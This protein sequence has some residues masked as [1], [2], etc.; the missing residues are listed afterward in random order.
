[1]HCNQC[2]AAVQEGSKFC[3]NCGAKLITLC[4]SCQKENAPDSRFCRHCGTALTGAVPPPKPSP[5]PAPP[6]APAP[7]LAA[8]RRITAV[9]FADIVG[10]TPMSEA[11][12]PEEFREVMNQCFHI[13]TKPI[14]K[15]DGTVDKFI[16]D[17]I[18]ALFGAPHAH[19]NDPER[20][21]RAALEMQQ[22][23][24]RLAETVELPVSEPI[25]LRVGIN[26]GLVITGGV[27]S[28]AKRDYTAMGRVVNVAERMQKLCEPGSVMVSESVHSATR[29]LFDFEDAGKHSVKG[30]AH[31]ISVYRVLSALSRGATTR[32]LQEIGFTTYINRQEELE[33]LK[34]TVEEALQGKATVV[35]IKGPA[36]IGKTRL[37][38]ECQ[39]VMEPAGIRWFWARSLEYQRNVPYA[40]VAELFEQILGLQP[41]VEM[42][43]E[44]HIE[45][46]LGAVPPS[47]E[48]CPMVTGLSF[49][50]R[51]GTQEAAFQGLQGE[52]IQKCIYNAAESLVEG[53]LS[54]S[55][56]AIVIDDLQWC[57]RASLDLFSH[58]LKRFFS[59]RLILCTS[60]RPYSPP[61]WDG[62]NNA[63]KIILGRLSEK[64][65]Q[66]LTY[67]I[68]D[69]ADDY[70]ALSKV[71]E[72][73]LDKCE[74]NA[75]F[76]EE[77]VKLLIDKGILARD[78]SQWKITG[79][80]DDQ[81]LPDSLR[82]MVM[83]RIDRLQAAQKQLLQALSVLGSETS[84]EVLSELTSS[85][86]RDAT[87]NC[88]SQ[89]VDLQILNEE[90]SD[91]GASYSFSRAFFRDAIYD[92]LLK[93]RRRALHSR[94]AEFLESFLGEK[95]RSR[96][97]LLAYHYERAG[98]FERAYYHT[99]EAARQVALIYANS[100]AIDLFERC[101][102][103]LKKWQ[104]EPDAQELLDLM[105]NLA[106]VHYLTGNLS[107][108]ID[109]LEEQI[110]LARRASDDLFVARTHNNIGLLHEHEGNWDTARGH[111]RRAVDIA[112]R[113]SDKPLT[114][115]CLTNLGRL[116]IAVGS[117][118]AARK[119]FDDALRIAESA[120]SDQLHFDS[121]INL[122]LVSLYRCELARADELGRKAKQLA[123]SEQDD[124]NLAWALRV[125]GETSFYQGRL[126]EAQKRFEQYLELATK[127]EASEL[128]SA[129]HRFLADTKTLFMP[130]EEVLEMLR[131]A[132]GRAASSSHQEQKLEALASLSRVF[133]YSGRFELADKVSDR[134]ARQADQ[135]GDNHLK[136]S[137]LL[138]RCE[139][140]LT[141]GKTFDA[142]QQL[143]MVEP[144]LDVSGMLLHKP[145]YL[146]F[147]ARAARLSGRGEEDLEL[148]EKSVQFCREKG[149][150]VL[151]AR[152]LLEKALVHFDRAE[153]GL[154]EAVCRDG[155]DVCRALEM[156]DDESLNSRRTWP[157]EELLIVL[158]QCFHDSRK[159]APPSQIMQG[160]S[161]IARRPTSQVRSVK[162]LCLLGMFK[163]TDEHLNQVLEGLE[164][165]FGRTKSDEIKRG[166]L[167]GRGI[168][169]FVRRTAEALEKQGDKGKIK[170]ISGFFDHA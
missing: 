131:P 64:D 150:Q 148:V 40:P 6:P 108:S 167:L 31:E 34:R 116:D 24:H 43:T 134:L 163:G 68:L 72:L 47:D 9:I 49:I 48:E 18:M 76:V 61:E 161:D 100:D 69:R 53:L 54:Q 84:F 96:S 10:S 101:I 8:E 160:L 22:A 71:R 2:G 85:L 158:G 62:L 87:Q 55:A 78:E 75:L 170:A 66:R 164:R 14:A 157:E 83:A 127:M 111:F 59:S 45:G 41:E 117:L 140:A 30:V 97:A 37:L 107:R 114:G 156:P 51:G 16:G 125:L 12:D 38:S 81:Q 32:G 5:K 27:G 166:V 105:N 153:Y 102:E 13:L 162:A 60:Y 52:E 80:P 35:A 70:V 79:R 151:L 11:L 109:V 99:R 17:C 3:A 92:S 142:E 136:I 63:Q 138:D 121:I 67:S 89:L 133:L 106:H 86:D 143:L 149:L 33:S 129:A 104:D 118:K 36:G 159:G 103:L 154:C 130:S 120:D 28:E 112:W 132:L 65:T 21:I 155:L 56:V 15:Y 119:S 146:L 124:Y 169:W 20:A 110:E 58:I 95:D 93:S 168:F 91:G 26:C 39:R 94:A 128:Q 50:I 98:H 145:R 115:Q 90:S 23:A 141:V 139:W 46:A 88:A 152:S 25:R 123:V 44:E 74:G 77:M 29:Q 165:L 57:D 42:V 144:L 73:I 147:M 126:G 1:V 82:G 135:F 19:E 122:A 113:L 4:P 7:E 137:A